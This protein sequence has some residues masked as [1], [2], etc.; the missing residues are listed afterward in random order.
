[1][2]FDDFDDDEL[3]DLTDGALL[4]LEQQA[5]QATQA[6]A[7]SS[8]QAQAQPQ[9]HS[10]LRN[11][12]S[13]ATAANSNRPDSAYNY[14]A[15]A[16]GSRHLPPQWNGPAATSASASA[17]NP[18]VTIRGPY[19]G[20]SQS[21]AWNN[22][23]PSQAAVPVYPPPAGSI[24]LQQPPNQPQNAARPAIAQ[25]LN[26][27]IRPQPTQ[28]NRPQPTQFNRPQ[29]T[30]YSR[31]QA[32]QSNPNRP[33]VQPY[34][35]QSQPRPLQQA[36]PSRPANPG[37]SQPQPPPSL[38][39]PPLGSTTGLS[40]VLE[41]QTKIALLTQQ[42]N[43]A[44]G[45]TA[46]VRSKLERSSK[47]HETSL[48]AM[49]QRHDAQMSNFKQTLEAAQVSEKAAKTEVKF[50]QQELRDT[51]SRTRRAVG[52]RDTNHSGLSASS[53][54]GTL[55]SK[56]LSTPRKTTKTWALA[57]GFDDMDLA[58]SPGKRG[59]RS[60]SGTMACAL[61]RTPTKNKRKRNVQ[62][63][64]VLQLDTA[65]HGD[66][67]EDMDYVMQDG[68]ALYSDAAPPMPEKSATKVLAPVPSFDFL[69]LL[70]DH[71]SRLH[72]STLE[73]LFSCHLPSKPHISLGAFILHSLPAMGST[74]Q[75][76]QVLADF[77]SQ[78]ISLLASCIDEEYTLSFEPLA[79]LL[80]FT[81][82]LHT[83]SLISALLP[84]IVPTII[85]ALT[86]E[87]ARRSC[88][89]S[90]RDSTSGAVTALLGLLH[91]V[92]LGCSTASDQPT[93]APGALRK[94]FWSA[95]TRDVVA[96]GLSPRHYTS[97]SEM[98]I[99]LNILATS[100]LQESVGPIST[101]MDASKVAAV[102]LERIGKL[103][104]L[105]L[106][107]LVPGPTQNDVTRQ[108]VDDESGWKC[109]QVRAVH[110]AALRTL[111]SLSHCEF[112]IQS[113]IADAHLTSRVV[114]LLTASVD[115][116]YNVG[117]Q[118]PC[119]VHSDSSHHALAAD[120]GDACSSPPLGFGSRELEDTAFIVELSMGIIYR[121]IMH[122]VVPS[123][124]GCSAMNSNRNK[125]SSL[126]SIP[127]GP[128]FD[129]RAKLSGNGREDLERLIVALSRL[130]FADEELFFEAQIDPDTGDKAVRVLDV[131][132]SPQ[133]GSNIAALF[134]SQIE[135]EDIK[136]GAGGPA[137]DQ[138]GGGEATDSVIEVIS[139][140]D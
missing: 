8:T 133:E 5:I 132:V 18:P 22:A 112:G 137:R 30:Q 39:A 130:N 107:T 91:L 94:Q 26:G 66:F 115:A 109:E 89:S 69:K 131:L 86:R 100:G 4:E 53:A 129:L 46:I 92:A 127:T 48:A 33:F 25:P 11:N 73:S 44:K 58:P 84:T 56:L 135:G 125:A 59:G 45:E 54:S 76:L 51:D 116:L 98:V 28:Y 114:G 78:L 93:E 38:P 7:L 14:N 104:T 110:I 85:S 102:V 70:L 17:R 80:G 117:G 81:L 24:R 96:F 126:Q 113:L 74:T 12:Y 29:P 6:Q 65:N 105:D 140:E 42:L 55:P 75:P 123:Q 87:F 50:L 124:S 111:L 134:Y 88:R 52:A 35:S 139:I 95:M 13:A 21:A 15:P 23:Q 120:A 119:T 1:M 49:R 61:E 36:Y 27:S 71:E 67:G 82:R 136:D 57:D 47:D 10:L 62:D 77:A 19:A 90:L 83:W 16:A 99:M 128:A 37:S 31:L 2:E 108:G 138:D 41:L 63:S 118:S 72:H 79:T 64:P 40:E 97:P 60:V 106:Y 121:L 122:D 101:D 32:S 34:P 68:H 9:A 3:D 20:P 43:S 103:L